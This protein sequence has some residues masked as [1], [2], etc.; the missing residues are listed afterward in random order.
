ME[1]N[2]QDMAL[3][4]SINNPQDLSHALKISWPTA[5]QLWKGNIE[6]TRL[7]TLIKVANLFGCK[8]DD[9]FD[10]GL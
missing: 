8:V 2:I 9:L 1:S 6:K 4:N 10:F 5:N 3:Q 7:I